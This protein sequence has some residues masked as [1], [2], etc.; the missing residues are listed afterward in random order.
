MAPLQQKKS[1]YEGS[2]M[3]DKAKCLGPSG[4]SIYLVLAVSST[5]GGWPEPCVCEDLHHLTDCL[6]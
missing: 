2:E 1:N 5:L 6:L 3:I 4:V